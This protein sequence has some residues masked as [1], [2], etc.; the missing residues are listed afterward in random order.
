MSITGAVGKC[1]MNFDK[2]LTFDIKLTFEKE[3]CCQRSAGFFWYAQHGRKLMGCKSPVGE[4]TLFIYILNK[5]N[6]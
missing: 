5:Y 1:S 6:Y 3:L 4:P 2:A